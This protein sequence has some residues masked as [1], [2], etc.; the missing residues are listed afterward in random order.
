MT[1]D[2]KLLCH[3][4]FSSEGI[5]W[6]SRNTVC[7]VHVHHPLR[8]C[9]DPNT[10]HHVDATAAKYCRGRRRRAIMRW[11]VDRGLIDQTAILVPKDSTAK[12]MADLRGKRV[13]FPAKAQQYPLLLAL[14][15]RG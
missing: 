12:T 8:G 13:A 4:D 3:G 5:M 10:E 15:T 6:R 14:G 2:L 1:F 9:A 11:R 7:T